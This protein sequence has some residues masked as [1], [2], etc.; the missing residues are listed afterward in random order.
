MSDTGPMELK[1][2]K[3]KI[4]IVKL[5]L[6]LKLIFFILLAINIMPNKKKIM[7]NALII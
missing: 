7:L 6:K 5:I 2:K 3:N 4:M 1:K